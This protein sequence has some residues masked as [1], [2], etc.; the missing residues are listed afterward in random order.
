MVP[1]RRRLLN[2]LTSL[3][4]LLCMAVVALWA[5]SYVVSDRF[6]GE[7]VAHDGLPEEEDPPDPV[8]H[9]YKIDW[10]V[11]PTAGACT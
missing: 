1:V 9:L 2:V 8:Y 10:Y 7:F 11:Y 4:L 3:S 6:H 5:R